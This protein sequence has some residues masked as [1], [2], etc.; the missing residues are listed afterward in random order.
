MIGYAILRLS[1]GAFGAGAG[2]F[3]VADPAHAA[4]AHLSGSGLGVAWVLPFV[5]MLLSIAVFPLVAPRFWEHHFG[6]IPAVWSAAFIAPCALVFGAETAATVV[7]HTLALEYL[8]FIILLFALFVVAGGIRV[9]GNL[10]GTPGTN[11][12]RQGR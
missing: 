3:F 9:V 12:Y 8:P 6:K 4:S 7:L 11:A 10:V 1:P 5:G 2:I